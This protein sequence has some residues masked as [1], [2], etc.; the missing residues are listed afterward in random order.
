[1]HVTGQK[2]P[3]PQE[4]AEKVPEACLGE[5]HMEFLGR[6]AKKGAPGKDA[7]AKNGAVHNNVPRE[8]LE[9]TAAD[10]RERKATKSDEA[11]VLS[12]LWTEQFI[13]TSKGRWKWKDGT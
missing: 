1:M 12:H 3:H 13:K 11:E 8:S 7:P 6:A 10:A 4:D 2:H 5:S 9:R